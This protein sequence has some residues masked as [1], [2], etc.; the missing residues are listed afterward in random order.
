[1]YDV[2]ST[3]RVHFV[4][5]RKVKSLS[6][7]LNWIECYTQFFYFFL[8]EFSCSHNWIII[9]CTIFLSFHSN[10]IL[11]RL[12]SQVMSNMLLANL[13][14]SSYILSSWIAPSLLTMTLVGF[15]LC[16]KSN[17]VMW[18]E[19]NANAN[20]IWLESFHVRWFD[21]HSE[22]SLS[23]SPS[24]LLVIVVVMTLAIR[25]TQC[26]L[27]MVCSTTFIRIFT[28]Y[29]LHYAWIC[30]NSSQWTRRDYYCYDYYR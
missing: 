8:F 9:V 24:T 3:S 26:V 6:L 18:F 2:R 23:Q 1:M 12:L 10:E 4:H 20:E 27:S 11:S 25:M 28:P 22:D 5:S 14:F 16:I 7:S 21:E 29:Q 17:D 30:N 13:C 15:G 19:T